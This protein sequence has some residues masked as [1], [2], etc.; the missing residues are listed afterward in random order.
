MSI[1]FTA[2]RVSPCVAIRAISHTYL[3]SEKLETPGSGHLFWCV[4][5]LVSGSGHLFRCVICL[6]PEVIYTL[7]REVFFCRYFYWSEG[8]CLFILG[9]LGCH[10]GQAGS[11]PITGLKAGM[12]LF[13]G[14]IRLRF[15]NVQVHWSKHGTPVS[16]CKFDPCCPRAIRG[17]A[18]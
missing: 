16:S 13:S 5:C 12:D 8:C 17:Y 11:I 4:I 6:L 14:W 18:M 10:N 15:Q 9:S 3:I 2:Y 1:E 7:E